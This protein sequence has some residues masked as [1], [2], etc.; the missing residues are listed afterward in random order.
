[1]IN[2]TDDAQSDFTVKWADDTIQ[3]EKWNVKSQR[4]TQKANVEASLKKAHPGKSNK[5]IADLA[6]DALKIPDVPYG[7]TT[8]QFQK[9]QQLIKEFL[10]TKGVTVTE[11]FATGSRVTGTTFNPKKST[12]GEMITDFSKR[13]FD[14]TLVTNQ[15][16]SR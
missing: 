16:I 12:F 10:Q 11:G 13:D 15:K 5:E 2:R 7:L 6:K 14:I 1:M 4:E 3:K 9:A 8:E